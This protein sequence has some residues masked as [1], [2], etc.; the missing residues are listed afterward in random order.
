MVL[1]KMNKPAMPVATP[2]HRLIEEGPLVIEY[3]ISPTSPSLWVAHG[4]VV[5]GVPSDSR[6][7]PNPEFTGAGIT[8][9]EAMRALLREIESYLDE[10]FWN[11]MP[12]H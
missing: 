11:D 6:R 1:A 3:Y 12:C 10:P 4:V 5:R 8:E 9:R 2:K 7:N